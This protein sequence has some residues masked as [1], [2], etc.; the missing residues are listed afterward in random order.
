MRPAHV[1][2]LITCTPTGASKAEV[3]SVGLGQSGENFARLPRS[4][5]SIVTP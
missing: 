1:D 2:R 5:R 3:L 4:E